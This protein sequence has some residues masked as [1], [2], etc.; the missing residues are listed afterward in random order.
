M[1]IYV[2]VY[3]YILCMRVR[4]QIRACVYTC[5]SVCICVCVYFTLVVTGVHFYAPDSVPLVAGAGEGAEG[6]PC[7]R[8]KSDRLEPTP[9]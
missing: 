3:V 6:R 7:M 8:M 1:R 4:I 9:T 2:H 5:V